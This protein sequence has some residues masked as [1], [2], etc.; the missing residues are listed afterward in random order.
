ML[1]ELHILLF[2]GG[3][4]VLS[5]T[6]VP[7]QASLVMFALMATGQYAAWKLLA[8]A[9]AGTVLGVGIN[10]VLG[11]YLDRMEN[12]TWFPVKKEYLQKARELFARHGK[13]AL[14]LAGIPIIGDPIMLAAG[15]ARI[16]FWFF[17]SVAAPA[18]CVRFFLVW[19]IYKGLV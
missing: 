8:A 11:Q 14:L 2:L 12:K 13:A 7:A 9:C 5:A 10:W 17:L 4:S 3:L 6:M 18:K 15:A 1:Q 16:N 19:L